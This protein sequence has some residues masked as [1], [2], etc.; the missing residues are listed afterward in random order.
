MK[1]ASR[2]PRT[3]NEQCRE[4]LGGFLRVV[5]TVAGVLLCLANTQAQLFVVSNPGDT[6]GA[7]DLISGVPLGASWAGGGLASPNQIATD[8][9]GHLF[10][11]NYA[12]G[13]IGKYTL[14]G[15][16]VSAVLISGLDGPTG[17]AV[18]SRGN[19]FVANHTSGTVGKYTTSGTEV[20]AALITG[21]TAPYR[22]AL[23]DTALFVTEPG[24]HRIG[25]YDLQGTPIDASL[26]TGVNS[27]GIALDDQGHLFVADYLEGTIGKYTIE[28]TTLDASLISGLAT[29]FGPYGIALD[30]CGHLFAANY[31]QSAIGKYTTS[32]VTVN[33]T[34]I[35]GVHGPIDVAVVVPEPPIRNLLLI[36]FI[37][38]AASRLRP[39]TAFR[40]L[41][42]ALSLV[43]FW[44]MV[45]TAVGSSVSEPRSVA[46]PCPIR[47]SAD[48]GP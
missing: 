27:G 23:D 38:S 43:R 22:L 35:Y 21:L 19:L 6:V 47:D 10:V 29:P 20:N 32:G 28:G 15:E 34:F 5:F 48:F 14:A 9:L 12:N 36:A 31:Y 25:K 16:V 44:F 4:H 37:A 24:N 8:G 7:Y 3:K 11:A 42:A 13:T 40:T 26:I 18:D 39:R 33:P 41:K 45:L 30:G 17:V 1:P 2:H 46:I